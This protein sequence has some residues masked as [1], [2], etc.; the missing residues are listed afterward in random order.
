MTTN[1]EDVKRILEKVSEEELKQIAKQ[2]YKEAISEFLRDLYAKFGKWSLMT[3]GGLLIAAILYASA[4][5]T[6][7]RPH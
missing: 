4:Y 7:W 2:A 3:L 6:G 5:L 1:S